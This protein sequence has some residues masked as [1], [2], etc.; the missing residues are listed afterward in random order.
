MRTDLFVAMAAY[1]DYG[2]WYIGTEVGYSQGSYETG[3]DPSLVA[4]TVE[5][6][7]VT[8]MQQLLGATEK[9]SG[10]LGVDAAAREI[11]LSKKRDAVGK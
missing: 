6:V 10:G 5:Q 2:P 8:A 1:G 4:P 3:P 11:E 9:L 7:L